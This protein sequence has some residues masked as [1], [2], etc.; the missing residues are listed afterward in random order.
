MGTLF[1]IDSPLD[2]T[3][4]TTE[5]YWEK[6]SQKKHP[7]M[8]DRLEDVKETIRGP[9]QVRQSTQDSE[10]YLYYRPADSYHVC[11]VVRHE[12]G[13]GFVITCYLTDT[14]KEGEKVWEK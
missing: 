9:S 7:G 6:I 8:K 4:R 5:E 3:A 1:E 10:V 14:I 2:V 12:N 13:S 11:V